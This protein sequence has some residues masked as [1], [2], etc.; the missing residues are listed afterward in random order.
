MPKIKKVINNPND[1]AAELLDGLV[2]AYDGDCV[3]AGRGCIVRSTIPLLD[4]VV[5]KHLFTWRF[6]PPIIGGVAKKIEFLQPFQL[7]FPG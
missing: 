3:K 5:R 2:E 1:C 6:D 4:E 7:N